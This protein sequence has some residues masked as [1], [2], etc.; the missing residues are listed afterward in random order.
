MIQHVLPEREEDDSLFSAEEI[1]RELVGLRQSGFPPDSSERLLYTLISFCRRAERALA[2]I[3]QHLDEGMLRRELHAQL[4]GTTLP[5]S[6]LESGNALRQR[7]IGELTARRCPVTPG[8]GWRVSML[9][10]TR[11]DSM[12]E[13][14]L[15]EEPDVRLARLALLVLGII[16]MRNCPPLSPPY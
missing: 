8:G 1:E 12:L 16:A 13:P 14:L 4:S 7:L 15:D 11:V 10:G 3:V 5:P 6:P 9:D 2:E